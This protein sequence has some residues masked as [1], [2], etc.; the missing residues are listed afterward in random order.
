MAVSSETLDSADGQNTKGKAVYV[1]HT[2]KDCLWELG[3]G[4]KG[5]IPE[6]RDPPM[7]VTDEIL[8]DPNGGGPPGDTELADAASA[9]GA[10]AT[11]SLP[12]DAEQTTAI[13]EELAEITLT[14]E[15]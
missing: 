11:D 3:P 8:S 7:P 10:S 1:L 9:L 4:K 14:P 15:G 5:D 13:A 2:W 6:P 12:T